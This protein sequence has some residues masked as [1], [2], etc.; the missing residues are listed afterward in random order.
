VPN[1]ECT[2]RDVLADN[3]AKCGLS[4]FSNEMRA[5]C[6]RFVPSGPSLGKCSCRDA[7]TIDPFS[8]VSNCGYVTTQ[9]RNFCQNPTGLAIAVGVEDGRI[10]RKVK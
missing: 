5:A 3:F 6:N 7:L 4:A 9:T 1:A 2:C 8:H 10:G